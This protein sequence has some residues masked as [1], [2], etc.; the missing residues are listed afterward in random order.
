[1]ACEQEVNLPDYIK[2]L[3]ACRYARA[4]CAALRRGIIAVNISM[5]G[6]EMNALISAYVS[7]TKT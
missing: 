4:R 7:G 2:Y 6:D 5:R 3:S 1:M